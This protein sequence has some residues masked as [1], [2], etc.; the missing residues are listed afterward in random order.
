MGPGIDTR[1]PLPYHL[2]GLPRHCGPTPPPFS[3]EIPRL[4]T[5]GADLYLFLNRSFLIANLLLLALG[6]PFSSCSS[7]FKPGASEGERL[8]CPGPREAWPLHRGHGPGALSLWGGQTHKALTTSLS[9]GRRGP[10]CLARSPSTGPFAAP[11][12]SV[13]AGV[14]CPALSP[15]QLPAVARTAA[16]GGCTHDF[17]PRRP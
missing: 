13:G 15:A 9:V 12:W 1:A 7:H 6:K 16:A 17:R 8:P 5:H 4:S 10:C 11:A 3:Y 2:L 14:P